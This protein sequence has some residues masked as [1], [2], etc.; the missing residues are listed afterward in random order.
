MMSRTV[1]PP[2]L[3]DASPEERA[4]LER[5]W[6]LLGDADAP[7][8]PA[9]TAAE[10]EAAWQRLQARI[11]SAP[12]SPAR[13]RA[14]GDRAPARPSRQR[15]RW[16][17]PTALAAVVAF[18]GSFL[19]WQSWA[20]PVTAEASGEALA[21]A[22]PDGSTAT[23]APGAS[24]TYRRGFGALVGAP[25]SRRVALV[26]EGFFDVETAAAPF[27]VETFN[28][29]VEVLGTRFNVRAHWREEA[30]RV[31][32]EEGRVRV[33]AGGEAVELGAGEGSVVAVPPEASGEAVP[34]A[35]E[36]TDVERALAWREGGLALTAVP[37]AAAFEAVERRYGVE[38]T[39]GRGVPTGADV[40]A[41][42]ASAPDVRT[43]LGDLCAA[44]GLRFRATSRGF[45]V[46]ADP[47][48]RPRVSRSS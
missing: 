19:A 5:V 46:T 11:D 9:V 6:A 33:R 45:E 31:A 14:S 17:V 40:T 47:D 7:G 29:R 34:T 8:A 3:H 24:L 32:V 37:L 15:R 38:I 16:L 13:S 36:A 30:T 25:A 18:V 41:F 26:G 2:D 35:P 22:L 20:A 28:A 43:V 1:L 42:Y 23:L 48:A 4:A 21:V 39:L 10:T 12:T 27:V 44:H